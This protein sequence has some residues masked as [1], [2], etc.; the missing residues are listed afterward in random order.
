MTQTSQTV[1]YKIVNSFEILSFEKKDILEHPMYTELPQQ[2]FS[3]VQSPRHSVTTA[4]MV[5]GGPDTAQDNSRHCPCDTGISGMM[6]TRGIH[7]G[8]R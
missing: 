3:S 6:I 7:G 4:V 2:V 1:R 8:S 5:Q